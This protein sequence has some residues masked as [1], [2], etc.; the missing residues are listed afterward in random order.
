M[1]EERV[2]RNSFFTHFSRRVNEF[3]FLL[4]SIT[5]VRKRCGDGGG[6]G[7]R[8]SSRLVQTKYKFYIVFESE[9]KTSLG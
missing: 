9:T 3:G 1:P 5:K 2:R 8:L 4:I 6:G 7:C